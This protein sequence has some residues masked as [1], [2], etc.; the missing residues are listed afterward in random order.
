MH[1]Y[2][3]LLAVYVTARQGSI[4]DAVL[5]LQHLLVA[6]RAPLPLIL[7]DTSFMPDLDKPQP[8]S[9]TEGTA[10]A[11]AGGPLIL[12]ATDSKDF[13]THPDVLQALQPYKVMSIENQELR[14]T[15]GQAV[16]CSFV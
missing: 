3:V 4:G 10:A 15:G 16:S 9:A 2:A 8:V 11:P 7:R 13:R 5:R 12:L 14:D 6:S 1:D